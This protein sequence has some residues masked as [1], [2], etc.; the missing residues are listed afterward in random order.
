MEYGVY[1]LDR[2]KDI[3]RQALKTQDTLDISYAYAAH[4]VAMVQTTPE[5]AD[6]LNTM[7]QS[8]IMRRKEQVKTLKRLRTL[9]DKLSEVE[10]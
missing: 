3:Y 1:D 8:F 10:K 2:M 6:S 5:N 7:H 4:S 9:R